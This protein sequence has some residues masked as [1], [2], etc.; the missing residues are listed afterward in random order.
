LVVKARPQLPKR[1]IWEIVR[2]DGN[3]AITVQTS[4]HAYGTMATAY[5]KGW[6]V[7]LEIR[8]RHDK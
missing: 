8:S 1:F 4:P 2:D 6:P 3:G 5:D 7:L